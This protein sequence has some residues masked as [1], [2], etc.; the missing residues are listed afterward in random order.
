LR[1]EKASLVPRLEK[2]ATRHP[3]REARATTSEANE[4]AYEKVRNP[5][6]QNS[7][8]AMQ[9]T[10]NTAPANGQ[11]QFDPLLCIGAAGIQASGPPCRA[12]QK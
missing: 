9:Q 7:H 11:W 4:I 1:R 10:I 5:S 2:A 8:F 6:G 3:P 12:P